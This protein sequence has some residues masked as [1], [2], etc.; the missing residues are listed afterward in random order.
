MNIDDIKEKMLCDTKAFLMTNEVIVDMQEQ[1]NGYY[2]IGILIAGLSVSVTTEWDSVSTSFEVT[3]KIL[4]AQLVLYAIEC[5]KNK[6]RA[7]VPQAI[8]PDITNSFIYQN[9]EKA[10]EHYT[11]LA[12][13]V[14]SFNLFEG[15][16]YDKNTKPILKRTGSSRSKLNDKAKR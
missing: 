9:L 12:S 2:M 3:L 1:G 7:V 11:Q 16:F 13:V 10:T 14:N 15:T 4:H 6:H 5:L 8:V